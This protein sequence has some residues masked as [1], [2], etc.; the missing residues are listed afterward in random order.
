MK[1]IFVILLVM[2]FGVAGAIDGCRISNLSGVI[3][4]ASGIVCMAVR[5]KIIEMKGR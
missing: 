1:T 2:I 3:M 4:L 5:L